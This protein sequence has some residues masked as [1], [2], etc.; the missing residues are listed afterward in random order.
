V[1]KLPIFPCTYRSVIQKRYGITPRMYK[2]KYRHKCHYIVW[3]FGE[4]RSSSFRGEDANRNCVACSAYFVKYLR[5]YWKDFQIFLLY[6]S[7]LRAHVG[8]VPYFPICQR[9]LPWQPNNKGKL[10]LRAF[11][12]HLPD[13]STV[14]FCNYLLLMPLYRVKFCWRSVQQFGK[15]I[16]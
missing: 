4:D 5:M 15:K 8:S 14:L 12:A 10:I 13:G 7:A 3:N 2:I 6:E 9:T 1:V 11:F 16:A